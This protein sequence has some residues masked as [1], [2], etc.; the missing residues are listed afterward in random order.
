ML[1]VCVAR[2]AG[3]RSLRQRGQE[4]ANRL[5]V[6]ISKPIQLPKLPFFLPIF[7]TST[8]RNPCAH[9][10]YKRRAP[11][12]GLH[13]FT[14]LSGDITLFL[15][16]VGASDAGP[17]HGGQIFV[18]RPSQPILE[19]RKKLAKRRLVVDPT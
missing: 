4:P 10:D 2:A 15:R 14:L 1:K 3:L 6:P 8:R 9:G 13:Q 12:D 18:Y 17:A 5:T 19:L 16:L 7:F 11:I